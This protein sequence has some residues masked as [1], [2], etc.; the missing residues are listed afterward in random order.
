MTREEINAY[1]ATL[2]GSEVSDPWGGGHD[3]WKVGG[4]TY[5]FMGTENKGMSVK[6]ADAQTAAM[7]IDVGTAEKA[8]YLPRGGWVF[9]AFDTIDDAET[10]DR[11]RISYM[12]VRASLT[13]K[14]QA[15]L[16]PVPDGS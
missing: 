2:P 4:K 8:P 3:C 11:L 14:L 10:R 16:G 13:K 12:T 7:L 6:C 5:V 1:C 9:F 15:S